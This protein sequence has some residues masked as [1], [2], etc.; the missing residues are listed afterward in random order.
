MYASD[1]ELAIKGVHHLL[2]KQAD[3]FEGD[4]ANEEMVRGC[5]LGVA[6]IEAAFPQLF[7]SDIGRDENKQCEVN[8]YVRPEFTIPPEEDNDENQNT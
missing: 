5:Y 7:L 8:C 1:Y 4:V 6:L 2:K 3:F